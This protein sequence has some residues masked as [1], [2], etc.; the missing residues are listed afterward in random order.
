MDYLDKLDLEKQA[1]NS[2]YDNW[3]DY[4]IDQILN[5]MDRNKE[6]KING[7]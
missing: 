4:K 5:K 6:E 2:L 7:I 1:N 3:F